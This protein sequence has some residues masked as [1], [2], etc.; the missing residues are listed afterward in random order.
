MMKQ[1]QKRAAGR[2]GGKPQ[3]SSSARGA[4]GPPHPP[5][6]YPQITHT[7]RLRFICNAAGT[8]SITYQNIMDCMLVA[9]TATVGYDIFDCVKIKFVEMWQ[10]RIQ[11]N[12]PLT[13]AV[14]FPGQAGGVAGDGRVVSD[15]AMGIEPAHVFAKPAKFA[16]A[17][18]WQGNSSLVAFTIATSVGTVV[19]V[20]VSYKNAEVAPLGSQN[21]LVGATAGQFYYR[22][23]DGLPVATTK[24]NA[25]ASLAI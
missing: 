11:S 8:Q 4:M 19:D 3:S 10:E 15:T 13:I 5:Q 9:A 6:I 25:Q 12:T 24:F 1:K 7:Q 20:C 16:G 18:L 21:A 22:G 14:S 2:S 23:L 17:S